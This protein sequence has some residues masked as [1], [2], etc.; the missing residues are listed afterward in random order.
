[1]YNP[2]VGNRLAGKE[3]PQANG[4]PAEPYFLRQQRAYLYIIGDKSQLK[5]TVSDLT[6]HT[7]KAVLQ[8][9]AKLLCVCSQGGKQDSFQQWEVVPIEVFD[10]RQVKNS[11]KKLMKACV[12]SSTNSDPNMTF[13]RCLEESEWMNL[14][15][16]HTL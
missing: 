8:C 3:S 13:H 9:V 11:F 15:H 16:S 5:V 2:D 6:D 1:M 10:M 12:P 7:Y 4:G 14:V